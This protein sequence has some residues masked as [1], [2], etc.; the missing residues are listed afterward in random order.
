M[1]PPPIGAL[2][3]RAGDPED[4]YRVASHLGRGALRL[5]PYRRTGA[6]V[7][8]MAHRGALTDGTSVWSVCQP[9]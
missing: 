7:V 8:V 6:E 5:L 4:I 2:V 9:A 3:C 1:K